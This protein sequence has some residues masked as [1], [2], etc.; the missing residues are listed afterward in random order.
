[1]VNQI[2]AILPSDENDSKLVVENG[3]YKLI[4]RGWVV[5]IF[6]NP[7]KRMSL[8][9]IMYPGIQR[10]VKQGKVLYDQLKLAESILKIFLKPLLL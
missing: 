6:Y 10:H 2:L 7:S 9:G 4:K 3:M 8:E 5:Q 1:M